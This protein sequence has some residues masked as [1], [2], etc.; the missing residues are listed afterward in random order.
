MK[1][2][3]RRQF[4]PEECERIIACICEADPEIAEMMK[5]LQ[6]VIVRMNPDEMPLRMR[7]RGWVV[8]AP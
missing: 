1:P 8:L 5:G 4:D 7:R 2:E 6:P 3:K